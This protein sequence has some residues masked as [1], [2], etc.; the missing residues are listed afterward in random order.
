MHFLLRA[1]L[2]HQRDVPSS[3]TLHERSGSP[4]FGGSILITSAPK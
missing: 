2:R 4:V 3:T 1:R